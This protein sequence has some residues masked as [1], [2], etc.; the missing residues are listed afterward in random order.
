MNR[1][2]AVRSLL[3]ASTAALAPI[4]F[5]PHVARAQAGLS[6]RPIRV[7]VPVAGVR[8]TTVGGV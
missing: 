8:S 4:I 6:G 3:V 5:A 1:R 7:V 2:D